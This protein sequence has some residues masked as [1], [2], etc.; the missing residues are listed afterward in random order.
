MNHWAWIMIVFIVFVSI[1]LGVVMYPLRQHKKVIYTLGPI[2]FI[3]ILTAYWQ[4][5]GFFAWQN[6]AQQ[7]Q[8]Q[9]RVQAVLKSIQGP[10]ALIEKLRA[11]VKEAPSNAEGWYWLGRLCANQHHSQEALNAFAKAHELEP[12]NANISIH[13]A[14]FLKQYQPQKYQETIQTLLLN[15]LK[16]DPNQPDALSMLAMEAFLVHDYKQAIAYWE[17]LLV[18]VEP[19]SEDA[20]LIFKAV[21]KA[22]QLQKNKQ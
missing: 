14:N 15:V 13:Y 1:I 8:Q 20:R 12:H 5:G 22:E 4:W 3:F 17:R 9:K 16:K 10:D 19:E 6:Y 11:R 18:L 21:T 7:I 2:L